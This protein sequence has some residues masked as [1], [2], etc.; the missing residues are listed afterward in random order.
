MASERI[1]PASESKDG[2]GSRKE[3]FSM[4][5]LE[6]LVRPQPNYRIP[7]MFVDLEHGKSAV[8]PQSIRHIHLASG[9]VT[10][11]GYYNSSKYNNCLYGAAGSGGTLNFAVYA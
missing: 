10:D 4:R 6:R 11:Y 1:E 2:L 7:G 8:R 5:D 3:I 9:G